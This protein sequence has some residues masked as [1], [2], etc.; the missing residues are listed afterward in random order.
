MPPPP[1]RPSRKGHE[2]IVDLDNDKNVEPPPDAKYLA[3]KNNRADE[4]T[5]ATD[6]NLEKAQ[7]GEGAASEKSDRD[8]TEPGADKQKIAELEDKKSALGRKAPDVTP[9]D[10][11]G[12]SPSRTRTQTREVAA[13]AARSGA[14]ARTS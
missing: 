6:T 5:R 2:K 8:D 12:A 7:K 1:N 3:Q 10:E 14:A 11:P 9:H 13:G 4:E